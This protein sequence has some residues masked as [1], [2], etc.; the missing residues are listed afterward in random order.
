M[1]DSSSSEAATL[2]LVLDAALAG[3]GMGATLAAHGIRTV[4]LAALVAANAPDAAV[5]EALGQRADHVLVIRDRDFR[6]KPAVADDLKARGLGVIVITA[7]GSRTALQMAEIIRAAWPRL[8][9][10]AVHTPRPFI[11][12]VDGS[13]A[14]HRHGA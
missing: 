7:E 4:P 2:T 13:G 1:S 11:V 6:Y 10:L 3:A 5:G 8:Q 12:R 14:M 9:R